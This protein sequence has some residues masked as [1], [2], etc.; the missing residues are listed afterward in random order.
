M[1]MDYMEKRA[2]NQAKDEEAALPD[3]V[4]KN[5]ASF[6]AW[7][8]VRE[9]R[10]EKAKY[11]KHHS[12]ATDYLTKKTYQIKGA[13]IAT[14]LD[15]NRTSIM[16]TSSFSP[17]FK[18]YLTMVNEELAKAKDAQ[19]KKGKQASSRGSIRDSKNDLLKTN[20]KLN[21]RVKELE[22]QKTEELVAQT[23][24]KLPLPLKKMFGIP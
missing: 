6:K 12:K 13:E 3:W 18:E 23:F 10:A 15:I 5:N 8:Y 20:S 9:L 24:D 14:A 2:K 11:I 17:K 21:K 1:V 19:L 4:S 16:N 22:A 7:K